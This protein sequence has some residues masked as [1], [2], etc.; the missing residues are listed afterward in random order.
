MIRGSGRGL[1][2]QALLRDLGVEV[3]VRV[4]TDS[5]AALGICSRQGLGGVRHL[6]THTLW[7]QQAARSQRVDLRKIDGER[8][9]AD[10]LTK[11]SLSRARVEKLVNLYD[12]RF[13]GGRAESAPLMRRGDSSKVTMAQ[14][15]DGMDLD[16]VTGDDP[17]VVPEGLL[18]GDDGEPAPVMPHV[19]LSESQLDLL[20]P[21]IEAPEG[22]QSEDLMDDRRD[23]VLRRGLQVAQEI[24]EKTRHEGRRRH[25]K[26]NLKQQHECES[27]MGASPSAMASSALDRRRGEKMRYPFPTDR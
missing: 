18:G 22:D 2:Y 10:L 3:P 23:P 17:S 25:E 15:G 24:R 26:K 11:H 20:Y 1:G 9:P 13:L 7:I 19:T 27:E 21:R 16:A 12:C 8:N 14:A 6:D 4:W 5:S